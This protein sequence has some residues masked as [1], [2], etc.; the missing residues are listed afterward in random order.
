MACGNMLR[1]VLLPKDVMDRIAKQ[2]ENLLMQA[3]S[4]LGLLM[5][6]MK[7]GEEGSKR[8]VE[9]YEQQ[10]Q[11][12]QGPPPGYYQGQ[13]PL[14]PGQQPVQYSQYPP[15]QVQPQGQQQVY[16]QPL[17]QYQPQQ[18]Y[19]QPAQGQQPYYVPVYHVD[20]QGH[21]TQAGVQPRQEDKSECIIS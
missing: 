20:P 18:A 15:Q 2:N 1:R 19:P 6:Q 12:V 3:Q 13:Q 14:Q 17:Q 21:V 5:G 7:V 9:M 16:Q 8:Q 11:Q 10:A 4:D